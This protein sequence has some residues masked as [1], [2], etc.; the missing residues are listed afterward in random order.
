MIE[1]GWDALVGGL[2]GPDLAVGAA[3]AVADPV[4]L[5]PEERAA[6]ATAVPLRQREFAAGR[7]CARRLLARFGLR[8]AA[9]PA[10]ADGRPC[11]PHGFVGSISHANGLCVAAV[12]RRSRVAGVG[13][14]I[15]VAHHL[16]QAL[17]D[18]VCT[19]RELDWLRRHD[20]AGLLA[21]ALFSAKESVYKCLPWWHGQPFEPLAIEVEWDGLGSPFRARAADSC[22]GIVVVRREWMVSGATL[23]GAAPS[24]PCWP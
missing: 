16:D 12:A 11:W 9:L 14:D 13:I 10:A 22:T 18:L 3:A 15:E 19:P 21:T 5:L 24:A 2:F 1:S 20:A 23:E 4:A 7:V 8:D 6:I 17:W